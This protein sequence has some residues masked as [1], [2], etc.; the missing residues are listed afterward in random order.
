MDKEVDEQLVAQLIKAMEQLKGM[1]DKL[2]KIYEQIV[3]LIDDSHK[4]EDCILNFRM[5]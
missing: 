4:L 3:T 2:N 5:V 1:G